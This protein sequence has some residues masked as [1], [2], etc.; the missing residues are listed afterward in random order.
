[1]DPIHKVK[2]NN[3]TQACVGVGERLA[4]LLTHDKAEWNVGL[5]RSIFLPLEVEAILSIPISPM[6]PVDAQVWAKTTNGI[7]SIKSAYKVVVR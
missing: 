5:V 2:Q 7:F 4:N 6:N 1:M 3:L